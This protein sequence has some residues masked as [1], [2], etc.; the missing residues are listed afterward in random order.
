MAKGSKRDR[1]YKDGIKLG[2]KMS[3][4]HTNKIVRQ[5]TKDISNG[6]DYKKVVGCEPYN[7]IP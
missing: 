5:S 2:Q 6:C 4:K 1:W 3:K 7:Y